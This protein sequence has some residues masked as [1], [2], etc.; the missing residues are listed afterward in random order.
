MDGSESQRYFDCINQQSLILLRKSELS[1]ADWQNYYCLRISFFS[2]KYF[3]RG[4]NGNGEHKFY[5]KVVD[6]SQRFQEFYRLGSVDSGV[7][8]RK[9]V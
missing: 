2:R 6:S 5:K 4:G 3:M 9:S 8:E 7:L 1:L